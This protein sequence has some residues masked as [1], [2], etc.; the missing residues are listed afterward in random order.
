MAFYLFYAAFLKHYMFFFT[1]LSSDILK[2][3]TDSKLY[4]FR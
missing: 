3:G 2:E 1:L 4:V